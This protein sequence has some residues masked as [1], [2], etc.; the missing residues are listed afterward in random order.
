VKAASEAYL[1]ETVETLGGKLT[2]TPA[3]IAGR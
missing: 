2:A 3:E 1:M